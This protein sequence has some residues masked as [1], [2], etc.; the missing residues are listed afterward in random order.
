MAIKAIKKMI[1]DLENNTD[2]I[3]GSVTK[4]A[5]TASYAGT[6]YKA[7]TANYASTAGTTA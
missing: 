7:T 4:A 1:E 6:A 2:T 5:S 3:I